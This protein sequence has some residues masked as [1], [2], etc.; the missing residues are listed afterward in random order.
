MVKILYM[1]EKKPYGRDLPHLTIRGSLLSP[2][3]YCSLDEMLA[4]IDILRLLIRMVK[5]LYLIRKTLRSRVATFNYSR[6][7]VVTS[8]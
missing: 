2:L 6:I 3:P 5:N 7:I 4:A 8:P 1:I